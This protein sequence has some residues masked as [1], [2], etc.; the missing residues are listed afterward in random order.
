MAAMKSAHLFLLL[1]LGAL[2]VASV[3]SVAAAG[4]ATVSQKTVVVAP[5]WGAWESLGGQTHSGPDVASWGPGRLD[6]FVRGADD[7]LWH[8]SFASGSWGG[9]ESLGGQLTSDP[10]AVSQA[11]GRIDVFARGADNGIWQRSFAS[12]A[13]GAWTS[14]G[15]HLG[16]GPDV[17]SWGLN[18]LDV[19][20]R[21][22][23]PPA[24]GAC[25]DVMWQRSW[26]G[27]TW[28]DWTRCCGE[29]ASDANPGAVSP[30]SSRLDIFERRYFPPGAN[31]VRQILW[32]S[33][34]QSQQVTL[35]G[36]IIGGP[37][38]SSWGPARIDLFAEGAD[39]ALWHMTIDG[40]TYTH[41]NWESLGGVLNSEPGAVSWGVNRI[42]VFVIGADGCVW[43]RAFA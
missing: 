21:G 36:N 2:A 13:W 29:F 15:G 42:D 30:T 18:R 11:S 24:Y 43:H 8:R 23:E 1:S 6:L 16:G 3:P 5:A 20:A 28:S 9:W 39:K 7:A 19:V 34:T 37:D 14:I 33:S 26:N 32:L 4:Q 38:P 40:T 35:D 22:P 31:G 10:G 17:A 12:N 27:T 25:C 41:G